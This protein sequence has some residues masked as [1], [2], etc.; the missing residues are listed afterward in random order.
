[1]PRTAFVAIALVLLAE[2]A[3]AEEP[4]AYGPAPPSSSPSQPPKP[5]GDDCATAPASTDPNVIVICA[6]RPEGYRLNPDIMEAKR[7]MQGHSRPPR[8]NSIPNVRH[9]D[10]GPMPCTGG[11]INILQAALVAGTMIDRAARGENVGEMFITD[12]QPTEYQLYL[13]AK[14]RREAREA[15][16][17]AAEKAKAEA[18]AATPASQPEATAATANPRQ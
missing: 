17:K 10:V 6:Q 18:E 9:C 8:P 3:S 12:P 13:M 14:Q 1:M 11:G 16:A 2:A 7:E 5:A 15:E 4:P